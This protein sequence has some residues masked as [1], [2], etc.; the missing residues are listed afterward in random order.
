MSEYWFN[1]DLRHIVCPGDE[2]LRDAKEVCAKL[3]EQAARIAELEREKTVLEEALWFEC[4][5]GGPD[6]PCDWCMT[7]AIHEGERRVAARE[8]RATE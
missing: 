2:R 3:A 7:E 6:G 4:E 1:P 8:R 5:D